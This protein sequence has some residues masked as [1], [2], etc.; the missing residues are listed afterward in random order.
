MHSA[1][2]IIMKRDDQRKKV[3]DRGGWVQQ[4]LEF[5]GGDRFPIYNCNNTSRSL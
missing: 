2:V 1:F 3:A 5:A 4:T